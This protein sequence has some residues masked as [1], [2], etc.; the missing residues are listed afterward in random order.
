MRRK[1]VK[2]A[3]GESLYFQGLFVFSD[4]KTSLHGNGMRGRC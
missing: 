2:V 3:P 4:T 1:G